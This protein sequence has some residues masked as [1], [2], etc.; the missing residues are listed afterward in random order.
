[1]KYSDLGFCKF[2][3]FPLCL[4]SSLF[5]GVSLHAADPVSLKLEIGRALDKGVAWL[6][7]EQN[8][9]SGNWGVAEY[10]ALTGLALRAM[11][12]HP[13]PSVVGKFSKNQKAGFDFILS[14]VQ[15]DGGIYGKGLAS[16][17]TSICMLALL[18]SKDPSYEQVVRNARK[19]LI[20]QQSDF[21]KKGVADNVFD[22]GVGYG[23]RWAHSDLS[24]THLAMEALFYANKSLK[25]KEGDEL[26]LDWDAAI[27]FVQKCQNLPGSNNEKWVSGHKDDRG[28]FVYFPGSSMAGERKGKD[29]SIAL[30]SY[31]SMSYAGLLSFI[32]AEMKENDP[33]LVA[34]RDWLRAHYTIKENP[35]M[36]EQGLY[37][38]YHTMAKALS[39]SGM[40]EIKDGEGKMRD[41]RKELAFELLNQQDP[42]G[43][44][45]NENGRWWER[46]PILVTAYAL[47][48]LERVYYSL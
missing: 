5:L 17:N 43:F 32:Y 22:G 25:S 3:S 28:G 6:N 37:Y 4:L 36:G 10:P 9:T 33:R 8:A 42:K 26:D 15:S 1:M 45:M 20:N 11:L 35:G 23:S 47:L 44:W 29:G 27:A 7:G 48:S 38:Y 24:N 39:L 19:F 14:K 34:V 16:Y 41:W 40:K 30:R 18:Q 12:G 46:D 21:D 31:G 2:L 13:D